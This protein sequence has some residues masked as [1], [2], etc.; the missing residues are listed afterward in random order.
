[1]LIS[2]E[3]LHF[4]R[5]QFPEGSRIR[6]REMKDPY[7]PMKPGT[8]GTLDHIDDLGTFHT[9]WDNGRTLGLVLGEDSFSVLPPKLTTLKFYMPLTAQLYEQNEYGDIEEYGMELD[10]QTLLDYEDRITAALVRTKMP[11]ETERGLMHWYHDQDAVEEKVRSAM[12]TVEPR[13]G[14][15]WG[16][17]ECRVAGTL[18]P[19]EL[20][21]LKEYISG[22]ASD[23]WGV[24]FEQRP[25]KLD[26]GELY[27]S[28]WNRKNWSIQT[29]QER[30]SPKLAEDLPE[31]CFS[32]LPRTG[33][34]I[35]IKQ[36]ESGYYPSDWDT[37]DP[38][39]NRE[40]AVLNN[41]KLGVSR[42]QELAMKSGSM[43][44]WDCP[45]ADPTCY[46]EPEATTT[47]E[48]KLT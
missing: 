31:L 13:G 42:A 29:E 6:L 28:F 33:E 40:L 35:Y 14:R 11:E 37:G 8:M 38:A 19:E 26:G 24:S 12:F 25:I 10:G 41:E 17:A 44:G 15:L 4:L 7:T 2:K 30:F 1:M 9:R 43:F 23:G 34:L 36:G 47:D 46:E 3:W 48:I 45:G 5:E 27:V 18:S 16:I 32:T 20:D 21:T 39:K 22:Q